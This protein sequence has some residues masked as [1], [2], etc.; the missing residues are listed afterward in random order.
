[1]AEP[2][3]FRIPHKLLPGKYSSLQFIPAKIYDPGSN[4]AGLVSKPT[5]VFAFNIAFKLLLKTKGGIKNV[6]WWNIFS[7]I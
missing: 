4:V 3:T 6:C 1:M 2:K 5:T 7:N